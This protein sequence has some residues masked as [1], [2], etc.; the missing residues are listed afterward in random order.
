LVEIEI[1]KEG[2]IKTQMTVMT[3]IHVVSIREFI[4]ADLEIRVRLL[5]LKKSWR[6][7][8]QVYSD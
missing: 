1:F 4:S 8:L 6:I 7:S 3:V 5:L 2:E